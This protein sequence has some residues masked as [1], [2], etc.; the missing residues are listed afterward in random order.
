[1]DVAR[2]VAD[3]ATKA[4]EQEYGKLGDNCRSAGRMPKAP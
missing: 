4:R 3:A 2:F 1:V